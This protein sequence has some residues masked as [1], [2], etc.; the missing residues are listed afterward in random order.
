MFFFFRITLADFLIKPEND[1]QKNRRQSWAPERSDVC[2]HHTDS[3]LIYVC[4][5]R[6][7][8][9]VNVSSYHRCFQVT[10][11]QETIEVWGRVGCTALLSRINLTCPQTAGKLIFLMYGYT[12]L[13]FN[14]NMQQFCSVP[15]GE[16]RLYTWTVT[17]DLNFEGKPAA[18]GGHQPREERWSGKTRGKCCLKLA[19]I[20]NSITI[21]L[22]L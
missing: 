22:P 21:S 8:W 17:L 3:A 1:W 12:C 4:N 11:L 7:D 18:S 10:H 15:T 2:A 5:M 13:I 14:L 16:K 9:Q 19:R 6:L 20:P